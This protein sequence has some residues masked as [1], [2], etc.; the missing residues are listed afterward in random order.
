MELHE[1]SSWLWIVIY[2]TRDENM[3]ITLYVYILA[4]KNNKKYEKTII[5]AYMNNILVLVNSVKS[6]QK[7]KCNSFKSSCE[8]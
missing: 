7:L 4:I 1:S 2:V 3:F 8:N 5:L 6:K